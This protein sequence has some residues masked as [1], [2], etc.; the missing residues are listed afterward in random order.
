[1]K[2]T[3]VENVSRTERNQCGD[4]PR[5][6]LAAAISYKLNLKAYIIIMAGRFWL[7]SLTIPTKMNIGNDTNWGKKDKIYINIAHTFQK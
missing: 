6:M 3:N 4:N 1:M 5:L 7:Q 2:V